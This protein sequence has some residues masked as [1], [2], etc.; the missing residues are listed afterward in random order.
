MPLTQ[1]ELNAAL[2]ATGFLTKD[3]L[4]VA[5]QDREENSVP[6][7]QALFERGLISEP[8]LGA[9]FADAYGVH[10]VDLRKVH[11]DPDVIA[12]MPFDLV[13]R[14]DVLCYGVR[15]GDRLV[16]LVDPADRHLQHLL[17]RRLGKRLQVAYATPT[18][19]SACL[20][21][22]APKK[23]ERFIDKI[24]TFLRR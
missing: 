19:L 16:A 8:H 3:Q 1:T 24:R 21:A 14:G 7:E 13:E 17:K 4:Q 23:P 20:H 12:E 10:F 2:V 22:H 11:V 6:L 18:A 9:L 15:D 5:L